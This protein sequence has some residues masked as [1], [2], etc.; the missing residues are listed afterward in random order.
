MDIAISI[1]NN[2]SLAPNSA[3]HLFNCEEYDRLPLCG[4]AAHATQVRTF[5]PA[6]T[7]TEIA[8]RILF[9]QAA[10]L[11]RGVVLSRL[12]GGFLWH[13]SVSHSRL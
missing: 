5:T 9:D 13:V 8:F 12:G 7:F 11:H 1:G 2:L 6:A 3:M 10:R 4:H